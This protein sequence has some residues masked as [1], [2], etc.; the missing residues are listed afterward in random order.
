MKLPLCWIFI[1]PIKYYL[2]VFISPCIPFLI[3]LSF[4]LPHLILT[5]QLLPSIHW[6]LSILFPFPESGLFLMKEKALN[7]NSYREISEFYR[8]IRKTSSW[9]TWSKM[10]QGASFS[11]PHL[12]FHVVL[13]FLTENL[14]SSYRHHGMCRVVRTGK[15]LTWPFNSQLRQ[16]RIMLSSFHNSLCKISPFWSLLSGIIKT[17]C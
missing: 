14:Y 9:S 10:Y 13:Q 1:L 11:F 17:S 3:H 12:W 15:C 16:S 2:I 4:P 5:I 6:W 7:I 8:D